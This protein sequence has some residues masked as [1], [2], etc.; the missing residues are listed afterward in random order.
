MNEISI[1]QNAGLGATILWRFAGSYTDKAL[2]P[3][4]VPLLFLVLPIV[5]HKE[6]RGTVAS[7][8]SS[9]GLAK[10]VEKLA[11]SKLKQADIIDTINARALELRPL[12]LRSIRILLALNL[13]MLNT[14][15]ATILTSSKE[16][17]ANLVGTVKEMSEV[18]GKLGSWFSHMS[19]YEIALTLRVRF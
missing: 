4:P 18:A 14:N 3:V 1:V 9:S 5:F 13:A 11:A 8:K 2:A 16:G 10:V 12:T 7:T 6:L 19:M 17:P 15:S